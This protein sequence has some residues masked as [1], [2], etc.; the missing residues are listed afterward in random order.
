MSI[1]DLLRVD[2]DDD[3]PPYDQVRLA[4]IDAISRGDLMVG[5][6]IPTVRKLAEDLGLAANTVARSY[7][8]L[9]ASGVIETRGRH[10]SFIKAGAS[11]TM[12]TAQQATVEH[13]RNLRSLGIDD[14]TIVQLVQQAADRT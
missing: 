3:R 14:V 10:G 1:A 7:R 9:E 12:D 8:E 4:V 6:R 2:P 13:V 11:A 5:E